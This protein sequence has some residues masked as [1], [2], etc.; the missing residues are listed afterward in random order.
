MR[1]VTRLC[2]NKMKSE[3]PLQH[4]FL[5]HHEQDDDL[6]IIDDV[7]KIKGEETLQTAIQKTHK[8]LKYINEHYDYD[9]LVR[10]NLSSFWNI[11]QLYQIIE[12][13][14]KTNI[15]TGI[16][17]FDWFMTGTGII[18]SKDVSI[19]LYNTISYDSRHNEDV[20]ISDTLKSFINLQPLSHDNWLIPT[21]DTPLP[22]DLSN[23]L[24]FRVK[25]AGER[26][27]DGNLFKTL[28]KKIYNIDCENL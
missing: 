10:T 4:F 22:D 24:Y 7:I 11:K 18:I 27:Y 19:K 9:I 15:A 25:S 28:A 17:L 26:L 8:A 21:E 13:L 6:Q 20:A 3:Y 23:I 5:E 16:I 12:P 2:L 14:E 1:E